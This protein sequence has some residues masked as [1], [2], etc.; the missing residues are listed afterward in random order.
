M[1]VQNKRCIMV[2]GPNILRMI[3]DRLKRITLAFSTP[4]NSMDIK[5]GVY[6]RTIRERI[7]G[8]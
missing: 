6:V 2:H 4:Y 7:C 5:S 1:P 8:R 3:S